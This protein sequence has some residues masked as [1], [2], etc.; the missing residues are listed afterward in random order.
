[1][2]KAVFD[3]R[4]ILPTP[5]GIGVCA[6]ELAS[7]L[8]ALLPDWTFVFLCRDEASRER[9]VACL[10]AAGEGRMA[11]RTLGY[12]PMSPRNQLLLPAEL[13]TLRADLFHAPN[14]MIPFSAFPKGRP[15]RIR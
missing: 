3:A 5:S 14:F 9:L 4:W 2:K 6:R 11:T 12:G 1:M 15:G 7:R 10:P 13:R 8:P